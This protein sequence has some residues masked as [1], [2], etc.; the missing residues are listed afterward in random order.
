MEDGWDW[1]MLIMLIFV[2]L[3]VICIFRY[4]LQ[5]REE[6]REFVPD[7]LERIEA[8]ERA[9]TIDEKAVEEIADRTEIDQNYATDHEYVDSIGYWL[10]AIAIRLDAVPPVSN[11]ES[12]D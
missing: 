2:L 9:V 8:I 3:H 6:F 4:A 5:V 12:E 11:Y 1:F 10:R 7:I